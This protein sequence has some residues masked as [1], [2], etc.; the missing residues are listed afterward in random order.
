[1]KTTFHLFLSI[2]LLSLMACNLTNKSQDQPKIVL[3]EQEPTRDSALQSSDIKNLALKGGGVKGI[4]Y[5][6]ALNV[7][8][9]VGIFGKIEKVA[10]TS[11]GSIVATL[12]ALKYPAQDKTNPNAKTI[13]YIVENLSFKKFEDGKDDFAV[14]TRYGLYAGDYFLKWM[15]D[16]VAESPLGLTKKA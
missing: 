10:G 5:A 15:E 6:G 2:A 4:A 3:N 9:S 7:L 13:E 12:I 8:D 1:M 16:R 11:A 14:L